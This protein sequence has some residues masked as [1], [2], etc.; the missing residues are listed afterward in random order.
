M[1]AFRVVTTEPPCRSRAQARARRRAQ[2]S[3]PWSSN[4]SQRSRLRMIFSTRRL[5]RKRPRSLG[6][7]RACSVAQSRTT[8]RRVRRSLRIRRRHL[9]AVQATEVPPP[10]SPP[11]STPRPLHTRSRS[12]HA[13]RP[14]RAH[15]PHAYPNTRPVRMAACALARGHG[16]SSAPAPLA[17]MRRSPCAPWPTPSLRTGAALRADHAAS[18]RRRLQTPTGTPRWAVRTSAV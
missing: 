17:Y 3:V 8:R 16:I 1:R 6:C 10:I 14:C 13:H 4:R 18:H 2:H 9:T 11:P 12:Q 5:R 15:I 7:A